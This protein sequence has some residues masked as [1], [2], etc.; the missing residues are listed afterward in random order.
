MSGAVTETLL[1]FGLIA[2]AGSGAQLVDGT[3]GMGFGVFSA[4]V[5]LALGFPPSVVVATV[6]VVKISAGLAS[7]V[8]HWRAGN[9]R[10]DWLLPLIVPG[11]VGGALGAHVLGLLPPTRVR[12]WMSVAL[13]AMGVLMLVRSLRPSL[14]N[15]AGTPGA[16][17][18][19]SR[20]P[21]LQLAGVGAVAGFL[22]ALSGAYGPFATAAVMLTRRARPYFAV[23]TVSIAEVF[24]AIA[25]VS[26]LVT[27]T[28]MA[29][30][31]WSVAIALSLGAVLTAPIAA[32]AC[33][34]LPR[35]VLILGT[36]LALIGLN[37]GVAVLR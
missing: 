3:L 25:V 20:L 14:F 10:R 6:N 35:R 36:G 8:S 37:V 32:Y 24:V 2:L 16:P 21:R 26:T 22:N 27:E 5:L 13:I 15:R 4:S 9:V 33:Q 34:R 1:T 31:P 28:G 30:V 7:G 11:M 19:P 29:I 12:T 23:G 18:E 17:P